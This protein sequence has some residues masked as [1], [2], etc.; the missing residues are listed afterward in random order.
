MASLIIAPRPKR[1]HHPK[2]G[3]A[4]PLEVRGGGCAW[5]WRQ[6]QQALFLVDSNEFF[7]IF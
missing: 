2:P 1:I 5:V 7:S 6:L 4:P 3:L